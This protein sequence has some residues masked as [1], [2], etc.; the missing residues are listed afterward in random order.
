MA[1]LIMNPSDKPVII[2]SN[3]QTYVFPPK[4][5]KKYMRVVH[6]SSVKV[7]ESPLKIEETDIQT[8]GSVKSNVISVPDHV[9][10]DIRTGKNLAAGGAV[11]LVGFAAQAE[12]DKEA[13]TVQKSREEAQQELLKVRQELQAAKA[14]QTR[15]TTK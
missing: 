12:L 15:H 3:G 8:L 10:G 6:D 9:A 14:E 5:N 11:L 7:G 2:M 1:V 13:A 4:G